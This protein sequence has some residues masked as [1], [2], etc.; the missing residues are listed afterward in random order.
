MER[1]AVAPA[2]RASPDA[3]GITAA[4]IDASRLESGGAISS[5]C[6]VGSGAGGSDRVSGI[7]WVLCGS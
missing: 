2:A 3:R 4:R 5:G 1:H 7:S 6:E